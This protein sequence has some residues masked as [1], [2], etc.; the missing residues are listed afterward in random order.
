MGNHHAQIRSP[1]YDKYFGPDYFKTIG[2]DLGV[3][4]RY[5]QE[6]RYAYYVPESC[7]KPVIQRCYEDNNY[8]QGSMQ[9][10]QVANFQ[11]E[12]Q[13]VCWWN[14]ALEMNSWKIV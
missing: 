1:Y 10:L 2:D 14:D 6:Q 8:V 4:G 3:N 9:P 12:A 7:P 13:P 5:C 11:Q